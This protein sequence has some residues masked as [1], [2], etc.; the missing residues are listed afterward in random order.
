MTLKMPFACEHFEPLAQEAA[1]HQWPHVDYFAR[2]IE[3]EAAWREDRSVS[4]RVRRARFPLLKTLEQFEWNWP[5][6][7]N[8]PQIQN[9]F[10]VAFVQEKANVIF[11]GTCGVGKLHL[12]IDLGSHRLRARSFRSVHQRHRYGQHPLGRARHRR[13]QTRH[14]PLPTHQRD[15]YLSRCKARYRPAGLRFGRAEFAPA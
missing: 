7:I 10:R 1:A 9:L 2:I 8:R 3:G 14:E 5:K 15:S 13:S 11:L 4:N 12:G 6:N